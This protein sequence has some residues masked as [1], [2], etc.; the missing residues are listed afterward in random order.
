LPIQN[1]LEVSYKNILLNLHSSMAIP[2]SVLRRL[3]VSL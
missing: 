3:S 1:F 2:H